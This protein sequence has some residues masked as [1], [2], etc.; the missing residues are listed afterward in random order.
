MSDKANTAN[1]AQDTQEAAPA[2]KGI[3]LH[4]ARG[5]LLGVK[6][7]MT[8]LYTPEGDMVPVT[9]IDLQP[10]IVTQIKTETKDGYNA[11]QVGMQAKK[12]NGTNRAERGHFKKSGQPGF[13]FVTEFR[14]DSTD[15]ILEGA[16]LL[17]D[18]VKEGELVDVAGVSKG[19]GF[20]GGMKRYNMAGGYKTHGASLSHRS[21][22]SIGNRAD[23]G[24]CFKNK[25]M[26]GQMGRENVTIHNL[27]VIS[28]DSTQG[29]MLVR[30]SVPGPKHGVVVVRKAVKG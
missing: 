4:G 6:A 23:P 7:G 8:Q 12:A 10:T 30:G 21:L 19:K 20:Q 16:C 18:F 22:G 14:V 5:G 25:K 11:V 3:V 2:E 9:V 29:V 17:P 28:I 1:G 13:R 27:R 26:P 24:K 15:G